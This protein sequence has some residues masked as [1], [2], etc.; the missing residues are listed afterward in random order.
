M[1]I[2]YD[3]WYVRE[4]ENRSDTELHIGIYRTKK[5]ALSAIER[6]RDKPGFRDWPEGFQVHPQKLNRDGWTEGF[7]DADD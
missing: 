6:L 7:A 2:V 4:R 5:D 3:L 1:D